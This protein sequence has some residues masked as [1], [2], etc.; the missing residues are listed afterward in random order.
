MAAQEPFQWTLVE[1]LK[2]AFANSP[3]LRAQEAELEEVASRLVGAKIYPHNPE[4]SLEVARRSSPGSSTTDRGLSLVQEIEVAGQR[5]KRI[6]VAKDELAAADA[7]L[8]RAKRLLAFRVEVAFVAALRGRDLLAVARTDV[9]L[10]RE[11]LDFSQR[12]LDRGAATQI[13]VNLARASA[14]R[15]ERSVQQ[16]QAFSSSARSRLAELAGANPRQAPEPVG[17][18]TLPEDDLPELTDLLRQAFENRGDLLAAERLELAAEAAIRLAKAESRPK[19][20]LGG[21]YQREEATDDIF[22]ATVGVSLPLFN[23]NQGRIAGSRA[24]RE[25]LRHEA[26]ALGLSI[27]QE[28]VVALNDLRAARRAA[29]YLRDQVLGTLEENIDLLQRSFA[30]G[31]IAA[32]EVVTLRREFV[33]SRREYIEALAD[34]W[35]AR[36]ALNL[37]I[38]HFTLPQTAAAKELP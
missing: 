28:V 1:A 7:H 22:G 9:A 34:V 17:D 8:L 24:T 30:A 20:M 15:A 35:Q 4:V 6:A 5:A 31:R 37:A 21:F 14:G 25:R 18:L 11:V 33:A 29:E 10:A 32:T 3:A 19:L 16:A 26:N 23:R 2:E 12:R 36:T 13:E 27:E 38:G